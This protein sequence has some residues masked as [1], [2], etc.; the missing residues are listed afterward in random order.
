MKGLVVLCADKKIEATIGAL[1]QRAGSLKIRPVE[2]EIKVHPQRDPGCY[3]Q[4]AAFLRPLRASFEHALVVFDKAWE[5]APSQ[6]AAELTGR[7]QEALAADWGDAGDVVVIDPEL[8]VWVWSDSPHVE[9]ILGWK[10]RKPALREWLIDEGLW[11]GGSP[12]PEN[13]KT[14]VERAV[15]EVRARWTAAVC[16]RLA[17]TVSVERCTD[18]SFGRLKGLLS[19]WFGQGGNP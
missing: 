16:K 1:L 15:R 17:E 9:T 3:H 2:F 12:K 13:P 4:A 14:A 10:G 7:V 5:G 6:D 11:G 19:K 8:E 18:S